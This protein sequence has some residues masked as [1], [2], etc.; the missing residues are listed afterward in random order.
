MLGLLLGM[1]DGILLRV[2]LGNVEGNR[3]GSRLGITEGI[4]DVCV[5]FTLGMPLDA[6]LGS[7]EG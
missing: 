7:V 2:R 3:V 6:V 4:L 5:S 1:A